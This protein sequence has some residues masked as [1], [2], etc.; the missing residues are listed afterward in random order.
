MAYP[1]LINKV[2]KEEK[3]VAK[4]FSW[5]TLLF[6]IFVPLSRGY[7]MFFF[8]LLGL[9]F[10]G[11]LGIAIA[12]LVCPFFINKSYYD[13]LI[14]NGWVLKEEYL[15]DKKKEDDDELLKKAV[16]LKMMSDD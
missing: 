1:T 6:G 8:I 13:H 10:L 4:G 5:T 11:G 9:C 3:D 15:K 2:T 14:S 12:W 7:Y 16:L